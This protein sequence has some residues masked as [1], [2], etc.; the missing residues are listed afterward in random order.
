EGQS[1][2]DF[3]IL[4]SGRADVSAAGRTI[5]EIGEGEFFGEIAL[6]DNGPRTAT[7]TVTQQARALVL[8]PA[9]FRDVLHQNAEIA[10]SMLYTV[11]QRLR[12]GSQLAHG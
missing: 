10:V 9:Q 3:F 1:G 7:V 2:G 11:V 6:L 8:G 5:K 12:A 4:L